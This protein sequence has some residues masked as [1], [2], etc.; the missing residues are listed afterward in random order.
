M[1]NAPHA[2]PTSK[3]RYGGLTIKV[4]YISLQNVWNSRSLACVGSFR[5]RIE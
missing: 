2:R 4:S 5:I 1:A 3:E